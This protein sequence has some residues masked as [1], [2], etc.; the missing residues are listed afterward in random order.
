MANLTRTVEIKVVAEYYYTV[1][2]DDT[3][4]G[5]TE[6]ELHE[7]AWSEFYEEAHR[8][9]IESTTTEQ[10][11]TTCWDC[12]DDDAEEGHECPEDTDE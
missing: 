11:M 2:L 3:E 7:M 9:S 12:E 1:E 4:L 10:D 8:A 6:E 5:K